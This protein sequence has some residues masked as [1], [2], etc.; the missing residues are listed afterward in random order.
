[1]SA[2]ELLGDLHK[3]ARGFRPSA[4]FME[5]FEAQDEVEQ[6]RRWDSLCQELE[7]R[8]RE[9]ALMQMDA[10]RDFER[11]INGMVADYGVD[12][13]TAL[14]WDTESFEVDIFQALDYY[15]CVVQEIEHYLY[16]NGLAFQVFPMYVAEVAA[17][18]GLTANATEA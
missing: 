16:R 5:A 10:Q 11:R 17:A 14:C 2:F 1:M 9:E 15:E 13:A 3:D 12:R 18:F 8:E 6:Q 4:S 7:D